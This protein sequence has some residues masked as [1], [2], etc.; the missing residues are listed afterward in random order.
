MRDIAPQRDIHRA[1][2]RWGFITE[3]MVAH[4]NIRYGAPQLYC[5]NGVGPPYQAG[6][7]AGHDCVVGS[8]WGIPMY[9]FSN[10]DNPAFGATGDVLYFPDEG[11]FWPWAGD[12]SMGL[13]VRTPSANSINVKYAITITA[14]SG[15]WITIGW[16]ESYTLSA[17]N[18]YVGVLNEMLSVDV[19]NGS[20]NNRWLGI[21]HTVRWFED[22]KLYVGTCDGEFFGSDSGIKAPGI[23]R[24]SYLTLSSIPNGKIRNG[25]NGE[26]GGFVMTRGAWT[27]SEARRFVMNPFEW[28]KN[29][30]FEM[31]PVD[32]CLDADVASELAMDADME[33]EPWSEADAEAGLAID[34]DSDVEPSLDADADLELAMDADAHICEEGEA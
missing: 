10:G 26:V 12:W 33:T 22:R 28:T 29:W 3:R 9:R 23:M 16:L 7:P 1:N 24:P 15:G 32:A 13:I 14:T 17:S 11:K 30:G 21:V 18:Y 8:R 25:W 20:V 19:L 5:F 27:E 2:P 6:P 34:G 31:H 4:L